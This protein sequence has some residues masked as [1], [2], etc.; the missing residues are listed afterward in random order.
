MPTPALRVI[1]GFEQ[2]ER[3]SLPRCRVEPP[4]SLQK[5]IFPFIESEMENV[6]IAVE[7][8]K[9]GKPTAMCTLRL[10]LRF[11]SIIL[12][13]VAE[14][15]IKYPA[16]K[17]HCMFRLPIFHSSD[18]LV[19]LFVVVLGLLLIVVSNNPP[20]CSHSELCR[21]NAVEVGY[22]F[23]FKRDKFGFLFA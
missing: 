5:M 7:T 17:D 18:F 13:D 14:I 11:R 6:R 19:S 4:E 1:A 9:K 23:Q 2:G 10:W 3:Y 16:R 8:E 21:I 12:Q 15:F 20:C 22:V